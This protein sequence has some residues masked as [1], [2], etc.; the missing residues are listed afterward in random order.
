MLLEDL[1]KSASLPVATVQQA[2][3]RLRNGSW[4]QFDYVFF[5]ESDQILLMRPIEDLYG[6]LDAYPRHLVVPH[7][8]MAYPASVRTVRR[9]AARRGAVAC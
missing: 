4:S 2:K 9:G 8:L 7:R 3:E 6:Y 5:T 1:P